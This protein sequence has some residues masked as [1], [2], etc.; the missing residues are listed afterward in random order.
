VLCNGHEKEREMRQR[1]KVD[2]ER[3]MVEQETVEN[4]VKREDEEKGTERRKK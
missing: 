2:R 3:H 4:T 1:E